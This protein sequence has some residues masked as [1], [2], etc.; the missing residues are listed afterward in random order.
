MGSLNDPSSN[1]LLREPSSSGLIFN[2]VLQCFGAYGT[3]FINTLSSKMCSSLVRLFHSQMP[4]SR[5]SFYSNNTESSSSSMIGHPIK[6]GV[7]IGHPIPNPLGFVHSQL[8][9]V[10]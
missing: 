8:W 10:K 1:E 4:K 9:S 7:N 5:T 3:E 6:K 2:I